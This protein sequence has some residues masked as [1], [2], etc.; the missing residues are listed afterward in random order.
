MVAKAKNVAPISTIRVTSIIRP[1]HGLTKLANTINT[2]ASNT[3]A[4]AAYRSRTSSRNAGRLIFAK[5]FFIERFPYLGSQLK[6]NFSPVYFTI[7][8][9][10]TRHSRRSGLSTPCTGAGASVGAVFF[11]HYR[12]LEA[13]VRYNRINSLGGGRNQYINQTIWSFF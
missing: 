11:H 2:T 6:K 3:M 10:L 4:P 12:N 5:S 13:K 7:K 9:K 8:G 1:S